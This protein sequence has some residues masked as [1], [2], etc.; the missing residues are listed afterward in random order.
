MWKYVKII[1]LQFSVLVSILICSS[2]ERI[3]LRRDLSAMY[4]HSISF[5]DSVIR[6]YDREVTIQCYG[7]NK[8]DPFLELFGMK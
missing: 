2:C 1:G 6:I 5:Q 7:T 3:T 4:S 8:H